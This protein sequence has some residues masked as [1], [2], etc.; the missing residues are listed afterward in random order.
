LKKSIGGGNGAFGD[1]RAVT[2]DETQAAI[3]GQAVDFTA[4]LQPGRRAAE[5]RRLDLHQP[6]DGFET[7]RRK[8]IGAENGKGLRAADKRILVAD[9]EGGRSTLRR[10]L[11]DRAGD[12]GAA[13]KPDF[14][15]GQ[16]FGDRQWRQG[17]R[18]LALDIRQQ[19]AQH[20]R[21]LGQSCRQRLVGA[22]V[23]IAVGGKYEIEGDH[24]RLLRGDLVDQRGCVDALPLLV[25][26]QRKSLAVD[27]DDGD[28]GALLKRE[29][30][31]QAVEIQFAAALKQRLRHEGNQKRG[32]DAC[33]N[34]NMD[35]AETKVHRR[36]LRTAS[37]KSRVFLSLRMR[38]ASSAQSVVQS[39]SGSARCSSRPTLQSIT[40][41]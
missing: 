40:L 23:F 30:L 15:H 38:P 37:M 2:G 22:R 24:R 25:L 17:L 27:I 18:R 26:G 3:L 7:E 10:L 21:R 39:S 34:A 5:D 4:E 11:E 16:R 28:V 8:G 20:R 13:E 12:L 41:P 14:R 33:Q 36:I 1:C 19:E 29:K 35:R 6:A 32:N 31:R 9:Q